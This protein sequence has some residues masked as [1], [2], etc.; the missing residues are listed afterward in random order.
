MTIAAVFSTSSAINATVFATARLARQAASD[1]ELPSLFASENA[2]G[3]PW[4]GTLLISAVAAVL[5]VIGGIASLVESGS[6]VF[7]VVFTSVNA[8]AL[9]QR[10]GR[11]WASWVGLVG[12][13][14][15]AIALVAYL[16]GWVGP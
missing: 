9:H 7:L 3:V 11:R 5:S 2:K 10:V 12:S 13:C 6:F 4:F 15:A 1:G 8:I 14:A 16:A